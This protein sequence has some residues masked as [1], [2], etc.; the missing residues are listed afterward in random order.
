MKERKKALRTRISLFLYILLGVAL[1]T[2]SFANPVYAETALMKSDWLIDPDSN[3]GDHNNISQDKSAYV[4]KLIGPSFLVDARRAEKNMPKKGFGASLNLRYHSG[5]KYSEL[6][7]LLPGKEITVGVLIPQ[8]SLSRDSEVLNRIRLTVKSDT[9]GKWGSYSGGQEWH[10]ITKPGENYFTIKIPQEIQG[11]FVPE[12]TILIVL[13]YFIMS[14]TNNVT[15]P[16]FIITGCKIGGIPLDPSI[17]EWQ[18]V[19][20]GYSDSNT[21]AVFM[22]VGSS[23]VDFTGDSIGLKYHFGPISSQ[24]AEGHPDNPVYAGLSIRVPDELKNSSGTIAINAGGSSQILYSYKLSSH[25]TESNIIVAIPLKNARNGGWLSLSIRLDKKD[26]AIATPFFIK[27]VDIK[28]GRLLPFDNRWTVRDIQGLGGYSTLYVNKNGSVSD[29]NGITV[30]SLGKNVYRLETR[31]KIKGGIDWDSPYYRVELLRPLAEDEN[32]LLN[33]RVSVTVSPLTDTTYLWQKPHRIRV[34][35]IDNKGRIMFGPNASLSEGMSSTSFIDVTTAHPMPKGFTEAGFD[36]KNIRAIVINIEGSHNWMPPSEID[37]A[38]SHMTIKLLPKT[39]GSAINPIDYS[40]FKRHPERWEIMKLID[41]KASYA[42]GANYPFPHIDVPPDIMEVPHAYPTVGKKES[43]KIHVGFGSEPAKKS[44]ERDFQIFLEKNINLVRIF[45]FG[46]CNGVFNWDIEG[47]DVDGFSESSEA[48]LKKA[49][50]LPISEFTDFLRKNEALLFPESDDTK[51]IR[52]LEEHV[53]TDMYALLD[54]LQKIEEKTGKRMMVILSLYD[55]LLADDIQKEGPF[56]KYPVGEHVEIVTDLNVRAK[57]HAVVWKTLKT[58][59]RDR[60]FHRYVACLEAINEPDNATAVVNSGYFNSYVNFVAETIYLIKDAT[61]T[62]VPVTVGF[63]SWPYDLKYWNAIGDGI[64]ILSIHYWYSLESYPIDEP[65]FWPIDMPVYKLWQF[66][67]TESHGRPAIMAEL[68]ARGPF[69]DNLLRIE[70]AGYLSTIPWSYSGHDGHSI[71]PVLDKMR[72][73]Q[74]GN[75]MLGKIKRMPDDN[76]LSVFNYLIEK[77]INFDANPQY[78]DFDS[79][80]SDGSN[81]IDDQKFLNV[82]NDILHAANLMSVELTKDN[83]LYL[84][85]KVLGIEM[86]AAERAMQEEALSTLPTGLG[87]KQYVAA[88][89]YAAPLIDKALK[90]SHP[91]L[92]QAFSPLLRSTSMRVFNPYLPIA[93]IGLLAAILYILNRSPRPVPAVPTAFVERRSEPRFDYHI[94]ITCRVSKYQEGFSGADKDW[95]FLTVNIS[96]TGV[97]I[98]SKTLI[99]ESSVVRVRI[100][101]PVSG[102][103]L[104]DPVLSSAFRRSRVGRVVR[105]VKKNDQLYEIGISL[106]D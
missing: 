73:Y 62:N 50:G 2:L 81:I 30:K 23:I 70:K 103:D 40:R 26:K 15:S 106:N 4:M 74:F 27:P 99:P 75:S 102:F 57:I 21:Y 92:P 91:L 78:K 84:K 89:S 88:P 94:P 60:R 38:L 22:P 80:L 34:G 47:K 1:T 86:S 48:M 44:V 65:R 68:S 5:L 63:R 105:T 85:R 67:G 79:Y 52:G 11:D 19:N 61:G 46:H 100:N 69:K 28:E 96:K 83:I 35:V 101:A 42:I 9:D 66:L 97:L 82:R 72:D 20:E 36:P 39:Q 76:K 29:K 43:D 33:N 71:R 98:L 56:R 64:D 24:S 53:L 12:N 95:N 59:S 41:S 58:F 51:T 93:L 14:G 32:R 77:R 16:S 54:S 6:K 7:K 55:F 3:G 90:A 87:D 104:P 31:L 18:F 49:S 13:E 8:A 37:F 45:M 17:T 25:D 10:Y